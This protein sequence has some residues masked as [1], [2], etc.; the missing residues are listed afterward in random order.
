MA[1]LGEAK[2]MV[3]RPT[4]NAFNDVLAMMLELYFFLTIS[5]IFIQ[6]DFLGGL[7]PGPRTIKQK[8]NK[9]LTNAVLISI[10][11]ISQNDTHF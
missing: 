6:N 8:V 7:Q 2:Q 1:E 5:F 11:T 3:D 10:S 9:I 4:A